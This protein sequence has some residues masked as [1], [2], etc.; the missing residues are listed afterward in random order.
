MEHNAARAASRV[1]GEFR[2]GSGTRL[3][4]ELGRGRP[5]PARLPAI[6]EERWEL[7]DAASNRLRDALASERS[8]LAGSL[9]DAE[10]AFQLLAHLA[11]TPAAPAISAA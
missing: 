6:E 10:A 11:A 4:A 5:R 2:S 8:G 7:F 3:E 9:R 1:I